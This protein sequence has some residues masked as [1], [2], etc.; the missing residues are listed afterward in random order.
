MDEISLRGM[1][2]DFLWKR[3]N[4]NDRG[5]SQQ[6]LGKKNW[7]F[8]AVQICMREGEAKARPTIALFATISKRY[9][10]YLSM[11]KCLDRGEVDHCRHSSVRAAELKHGRQLNWCWPTTNN[12][13]L[14]PTSPHHWSISMS[15]SSQ[16]WSEAPCLR[17]NDL[18]NGSIIDWPARHVS[19][20]I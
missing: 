20:R 16:S 5:I 9:V 13:I 11:E 7:A 10:S 14:L 17:G 6:R 18:P 4:V 12:S 19:C 15:L 2:Y 3:E 1:R 8:N